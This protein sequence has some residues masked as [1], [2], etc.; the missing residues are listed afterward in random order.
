MMFAFRLMVYSPAAL[1]VAPEGAQPYL[2][3]RTTATLGE[4]VI[5]NNPP[6]SR[7][8]TFVA[9][10]V[11]PPFLLLWSDLPHVPAQTKISQG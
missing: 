4:Q 11:A 7:G 6:G 1:E 9:T 10:F 2:F 3:M 8:W 5:E